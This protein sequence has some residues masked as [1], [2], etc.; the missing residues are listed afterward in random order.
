MSKILSKKAAVLGLTIAIVA[1][2]AAYAYFTASGTGSGD[3]SVDETIAP[4]T[5]SSDDF[6]LSHFGD[7]ANVDIV[8]SNT[9]SSAQRL[10]SLSVEVTKAPTGCDTR[11]FKI[12]GVESTPTTEVPAASSTGPGTATVDTV[13]VEFVNLADSNQNSCLSGPVTLGYNPPAQP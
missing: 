11:S 5:L 2:V 13:T 1:A 10:S 3:G 12:T 8:A 6:T 7:T 9:G 4:M